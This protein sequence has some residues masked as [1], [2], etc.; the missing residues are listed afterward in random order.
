MRWRKASHARLRYHCAAF[1]LDRSALLKKGAPCG[2]L[3][4]KVEDFTP[5]SEP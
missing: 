4:H 1:V 5:P 3:V 2:A